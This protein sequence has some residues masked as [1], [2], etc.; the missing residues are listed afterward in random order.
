MSVVGFH[1]FPE[2]VKGGFVGVDVFFVIS[3]YL[4][5]SIILGSLARGTF[6]FVEFYSRRVRRIFPALAVV[7]VALHFIGWFALLPEEY[8]ALGRHIAGGAGFISNFFL[9]QDS[10]YFDGA[11]ETKPLLHLWSLGIEEQFYIVWPSLLYVA[12]TRR[13]NLFLVILL[14][15]LIS[16]SVNV[17]QVHSNAIA[18]FYSPATRFWELLIGSV[19]ACLSMDKRVP[20]AEAGQ[21][22][23]SIPGSVT[24]R[25]ETLLRDIESALGFILIAA[26]ILALNRNMAFP[27]WWAL[28]PT[29]GAYLVISAGPAAF[30]NRVVLAHPVLVWFGLI[31]F[32]LYLW[33]WPL[34]SVA[35][36]ISPDSPSRGMRLT[37]VAVSV[38]LAWLTYRL[39]EIPIRFGERGNVKA[40]A[41]CVFLMLTGSAGY[42]AYVHDGWSERFI[43]VMSEDELVAQRNRYW[44]RG[45]GLAF[46][47]G[48]TNVIVFGDSQARDIVAALSHDNRLRLKFFPSD[49][50]CSAFFSANRGDERYQEACRKS[51]DALITSEEIRTADVLIY[52]HYWRHEIEDTKNYAEGLRQIR[53]Q[54][55][56]LRVY[57]F[58]NKPMLG[59]RWLSINRITRRHR[60]RAGIN[61]YLDSIKVIP[62]IDNRYARMLAGENGVAFLDVAKV[63]CDGGCPFF[64]D[65]RFSYFDTE[66]WTEMGAERFFDRLVKSA[67][68]TELVTRPP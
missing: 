50:T 5:S 51:F 54:N 6:G 38:A 9:W 8:K 18:A 3:G 7:L 45:E 44:N 61:E 63:F 37:I 22:W 10:G 43:A 29:V 20:F 13:S 19:L 31:S 65:D 57:F 39:I 34:L 58:G 55:G 16:F 28:L 32:P 36:M 59:D 62:E 26:A 27:G 67:E 49:F 30:L 12:W 41:L 53:A 68:Y 4:I 40:V 21:P 33:H 56:K 60:A 47:R 46:D 11:A 15:A 17:G 14:I 64:E 52:A 48:F 2:L 25:N 35:Y 66:H 1:A 42:I 24:F 23:W